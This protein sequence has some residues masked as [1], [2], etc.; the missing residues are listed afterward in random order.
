MNVTQVQDAAT[1]NEYLRS[2]L[3][4]KDGSQRKR[5]SATTSSSE[6]T[7]FINVA[8]TSALGYESGLALYNDTQSAISTSIENGVFTTTLNQTVAS[9]ETDEAILSVFISNQNISTSFTGISTP[10]IV[11]NDISVLHPGQNSRVNKLSTGAVTAIAICGLFVTVLIILYCI[12]TIG[13]G[14]SKISKRINQIFHHS[15]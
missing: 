7:Y 12:D 5:L 9:W 4:T 3:F 6:I 10:V 13:Y 11:T 15:H 8:S 1:S 14:V 2:Y